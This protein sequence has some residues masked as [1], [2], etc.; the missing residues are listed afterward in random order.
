M[1]FAEWAAP[2]IRLFE[3]RGCKLNEMMISNSVSNDLSRLVDILH[4]KVSETNRQ[5]IKNLEKCD[6]PATLIVNKRILYLYIDP[7]P[8]KMRIIRN[9]I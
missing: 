5:M 7:R 2:K 9:F 4:S 3:C 8:Q 1:P 6:S